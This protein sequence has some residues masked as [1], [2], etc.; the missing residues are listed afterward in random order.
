[1]YCIQKIRCDMKETF[2]L[3]CKTFLRSRLLH[4]VGDIVERL[5]SIITSP[6]CHV[7]IVA[8]GALRMTPID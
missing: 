6:K 4:D 8:K 3:Q 2:S 7:L 1:M 5:E